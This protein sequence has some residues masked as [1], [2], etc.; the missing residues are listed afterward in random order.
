MRHYWISM[1]INS[2]KEII[3]KKYLGDYM[4]TKDYNDM[5]TSMNVSIR[6]SMLPGE[7]VSQNTKEFKK[8]ELY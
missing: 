1:K 4:I 7:S 5:W 8:I 2:P 6:E 3:M